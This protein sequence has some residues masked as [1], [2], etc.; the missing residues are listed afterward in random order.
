MELLE[1]NL[2]GD[3]DVVY[4]IE[5]PVPR[6]PQQNQLVIGDHAVFH[7]VYQD[8]WRETPPPGWFPVGVFDPLDIFHSNARPALR[9]ALCL[10]RLSA[11]IAP[12]ELVLLGY[13]LLS[14][15]DYSLD[16]TDADGVLN[17]EACEFYRCHREY[18]P[19]TRAGLFDDWKPDGAT[20]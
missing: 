15:Q 19:L 11:G 5:M 3:L 10:G 16:E 14:L 18:L 8:E 9:G 17:L 1:V 7:L 12:K 4:R 2:F 13:Y 20:T 6:W